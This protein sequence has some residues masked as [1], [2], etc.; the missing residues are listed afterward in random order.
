MTLKQ[1]V[2]SFGIFTHELRSDDPA[3]HNEII[4]ASAELEAL[5]FGTL[6]LGGSS[7]IK[8]A[9]RVLA[10]TSEISV[11]TGILS[12]WREAAADVAG[13]LAALEPVHRDRF[14][15]GLGA[16]HASL[17]K[18]Y[19]RPYSSM[20]AY[21]DVLDAAQAPV[22]A[23]RRVLAALGP[24]MLE[25]SR[26]RAAGA[27]PYL[28]TPEHTERARTTLGPLPL[29]A[30]ELAVVLESDP[31]RARAIARTY[32]EYYLT[33]PNYLSNLRRLG[34]DDDD[35]ADRGSNRLV[36]SVVAWGTD[37]AIRNRVAEFH[38]AGADHVALQV[39]SDHD[40]RSMPR[41]EWRRL[42]GI[43]GLQ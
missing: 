34:F 25:L 5:G 18:D 38:A 37:S 3:L 20:K 35:V 12:I 27:H 36:D 40:G 19:Q 26:D 2:G 32:T 1:E 41:R 14:V 23:E 8:H 24:K 17:A 16:S 29:L 31:S 7:S 33:L 6:W 21:L 9:A 11:A 28:V 42:A 4:E 13:Q 22:S 15:L 10:A 30:P 39:I 43:L